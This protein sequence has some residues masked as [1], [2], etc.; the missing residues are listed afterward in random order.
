MND[1]LW[2]IIIGGLVGIGLIVLSVN[3]MFAQIKTW[4]ILEEIIA[5][6]SISKVSEERKKKESN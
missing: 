5:C 1:Y 4:R 6:G 2:L 3:A